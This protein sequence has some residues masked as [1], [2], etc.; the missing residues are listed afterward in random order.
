MAL[1][2]LYTEDEAEELRH[3]GDMLAFAG[4]VLVESIDSC[5]EGIVA[6]SPA[7]VPVYVAGTSCIFCG[8][9][10]CEWSGNVLLACTDCGYESPLH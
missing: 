2:R 8:S 4:E 3:A 7:P 1:R 5:I 9:L 10:A 6:I